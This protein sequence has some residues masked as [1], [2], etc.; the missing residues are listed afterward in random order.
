MIKM[1]DLT[2]CVTHK[3]YLKIVVLLFS[4]VLNRGNLILMSVFYFP[5]E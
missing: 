2:S 5:S 4:S 3:K 1:Q